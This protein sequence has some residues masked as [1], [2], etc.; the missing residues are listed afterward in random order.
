MSKYSK[1]GGLMSE[2]QDLLTDID[3]AIQ[4]AL[5]KVEELR[6]VM[7]QDTRLEKLRSRIDKEG[8]PTSYSYGKKQKLEQHEEQS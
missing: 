4:H 7:Q 1:L 8:I 6:E 3:L 5:L 2:Q